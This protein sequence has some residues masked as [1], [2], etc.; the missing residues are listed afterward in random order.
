MFF[1]RQRSSAEVFALVEGF[2]KNDIEQH[3]GVETLET[4]CLE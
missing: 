4:S 2:W 3:L 1:R